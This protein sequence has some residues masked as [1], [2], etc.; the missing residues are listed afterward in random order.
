MGHTIRLHQEHH[1]AALWISAVLTR[2]TKVTM[3]SLSPCKSLN[4]TVVSGR[5]AA[6]GPLGSCTPCSSFCRGTGVFL[7]FTCA[8]F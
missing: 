8:E 7:R 1:S 3:A 4:S 2:S 5:H 6:W